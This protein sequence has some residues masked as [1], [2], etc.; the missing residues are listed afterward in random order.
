MQSNKNREY[1]LLFW[2][3][4]I[5][6]SGFILHY[7]LLIVFLIEPTQSF[8]PIDILNKTTKN[9]KSTYLW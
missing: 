1:I 6:L 5:S 2:I 3:D 7:F 8:P 4:V 9:N